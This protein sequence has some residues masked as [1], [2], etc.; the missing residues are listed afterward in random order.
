MSYFTGILFFSKY[1]TARG[2]KAMAASMVAGPGRA[3][4]SCPIVDARACLAPEKGLMAP[5][6]PAHALGEEEWPI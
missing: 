1:S 2:T 5:G 3:R 4:G 6:V